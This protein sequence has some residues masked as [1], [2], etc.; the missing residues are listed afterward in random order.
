MYQRELSHEAKLIV[1]G[2][3]EIVRAISAFFGRLQRWLAPRA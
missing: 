3:L 2:R 1:E